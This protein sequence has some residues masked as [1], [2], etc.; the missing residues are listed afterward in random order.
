MKVERQLAW[1][2]GVLAAFVLLI[3]LFKSILLPFVLGTAVAYFLDPVADLLERVMPRWLATAVLTISAILV[4]VAFVFLLVPLLQAQVLTLATELPAYGETLRIFLMDILAN[5]QARLPA[6][7]V[8]KLREAF[9]GLAGSTLKW[10]GGLLTGLWSGGLALLNLISLVVITPVVTFYLLRDWDKIVERIDGLLPRQHAPV[11]REQV[12]RIDE[13]LAAFVRGQATVCLMLGIFYAVGLSIVGL[14]FGLIIGLA[15]GLISFVPYFGM[16]IGLV[17]SV[18]LAFA[19]F[20]E[21]GPIVAVAAIFIAGQ[22][23]EGNIVSPKLVGDKVG[24]HPVWMIFALMGGGAIFGFLG[25]LLAVPV[26]ASIGVL[27][28]FAIEQYV[29]GALYD[30]G[31]RQDP[32]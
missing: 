19:Q 16:I 1:W 30:H 18:G 17:V 22:V 24:L 7:D 9:A 6:E 5:L 12:S 15:T 10:A 32:P 29:A 3:V 21:W 28:R 8:E 13:T 11:I 4:F 23:I 31:P 14:E 27:I 25:V 2:A 26:A 20:S